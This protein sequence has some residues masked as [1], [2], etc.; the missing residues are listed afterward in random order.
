MR[1]ATILATTFL[2]MLG[3]QA[4]AET[5]ALGGKAGTLG[6]GAELTTQLSRSMNGRLG[7]NAFNYSSSGTHNTINYNSKLQLQTVDALAD[8][9]LFDNNFRVSAGVFYNNNQ[10]TLTGQPTGGSYVING[11]TYSAAQVGSLQG[12]MT[13]NNFAP[14]F[15]IGWGDP[16]SSGA[17]WSVSS[18]LGILFQGAPK[19]TLTAA[20]GAG[21]TAPQCTALQNNATAEQSQLENSLRN[22]RYYPIASISVN[23]QW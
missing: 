5:L 10:A 23:Y 2:T 18:D 9:F 21:M 11:T 19:A 15:G 4:H 22:Y 3:T 17:G 14:Y 13:F 12:K 7:I 6:L 20:C 8:W 1:L 16:V